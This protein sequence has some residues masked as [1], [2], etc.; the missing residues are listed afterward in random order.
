M[1]WAPRPQG[2]GR[3]RDAWGT[4][5]TERAPPRPTSRA[6]QVR[7]R[8]AARD[9][10]A[11]RH[12]GASDADRGTE[13]IRLGGD[14]TPPRGGA[15]A[16]LDAR[17]RP[18]R[19][20]GAAGPRRGRRRL[21][22][23]AR[24][25]AGARRDPLALRRPPVL[26]RCRA[27]DREGAGRRE[28]HLPDRFQPSDRCHRLALGRRDGRAREARRRAPLARGAREGPPGL[29]PL[30]RPRRPR[31]A[32]ALAAPA[33]AQGEHRAFRRCPLGLRLDQ[34]EPRGDQDTPRVEGQRPRPARRRAPAAA[35]R[36]P[37]DPDA[38][39]EQGRRPGARVGDDR[40]P[41][42]QL[43]PRREQ[44]RRRLGDPRPRPRRGAARRAALEA[45]PARAGHR[46]RRHGRAP[47][48]VRRVR[49]AGP[50]REAPRAAAGRARPGHPAEHPRRPRARPRAGARRRADGPG[51][52][53]RLGQGAAEL[54]PADRPR[55]RAGPHAVAGR[56]EGLS[57]ED[58]RPGR[59]RG[60]DPRPA[61]RARAGDGRHHPGRA[62]GRAGPG[63]RARLGRRGPRPAEL[64]SA[65][66]AWCRSR[67]RCGGGARDGRRPARVAAARGP[68][69]AGE[70]PLGPVGGC[71]PR[72]PCRARRSGSATSS[73]ATPEAAAG[74]LQRW[75]GGTEGGPRP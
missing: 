7:W 73:A 74:V 35:P 44:P 67:P 70:R 49:Q 62:G 21:R 24:A 16:D 14:A 31:S 55:Q 58:A 18:R 61:A 50:T 75:I 66:R 1:R 46:R 45:Q 39:G 8:A 51:P 32:R 52:R 34:A 11:M 47:V 57:P 60:R 71:A 4:L 2:W 13:V 3:R 37:L 59:S 43:L 6:P 33:L 54:L 65:R 72:G 17:P 10:P 15:G 40:R 53:E 23:A 5:R 42:G 12:G 64:G 9:G 69:G 29:R 48:P 63:R 25:A 30:V 27:R 41:V 38:P 26:R 36:D 22:R 68:A 20:A 28:D 19:A 56:P